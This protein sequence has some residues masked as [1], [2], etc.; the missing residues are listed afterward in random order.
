[1]TMP[2]ALETHWAG[3]ITTLPSL[4][5]RSSPRTAPWA[6]V[7]VKGFDEAKRRLA[8]V[9]S[10]PDRAA[11]AEAMLRQVLQTLMA[12]AG[13]GGVLVVTADQRA[14]SLALHFGAEVLED[15]G[16]GTNAAVVRGL[17]SLM[18]RGRHAAVVVPGDVPLMT[19]AE[20]DEV[21]ARGREHAVVLVPATRDGGTNLLLTR[22]P[23]LFAP[24]FGPDSFARRRESARA[25]GIEP[26]VLRLDGLGLDIDTSDDLERVMTRRSWLGADDI[27]SRAHR[28]SATS[29]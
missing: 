27:L 9:L 28:R 7:P 20:I 24:C 18:S 14:A 8:D 29:A 22:P 11:F 19:P 23:G 1:M 21:L 3:S 4:V 25:L 13:L 2:M 15:L 16:E 17:D 10:A 5:E 12:T 26:C 6:V